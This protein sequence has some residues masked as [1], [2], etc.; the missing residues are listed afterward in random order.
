[1]NRVLALAVQ[2][3]EVM[4]FVLDHIEYTDELAECIQDSLQLP[5]TPLDS[6]VR[7]NSWLAACTP[8]Q[9]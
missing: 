3:R 8:S 4:G 7:Q 6:K 2:V 5:D 1:M 9:G